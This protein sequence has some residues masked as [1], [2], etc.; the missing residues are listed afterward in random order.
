MKNSKY[1]ARSIFSVHYRGPYTILSTAPRNCC[2]TINN[3][4]NG[5]IRNQKDQPASRIGIDNSEDSKNA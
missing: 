1:G 2:L 3:V 4:P 5:S